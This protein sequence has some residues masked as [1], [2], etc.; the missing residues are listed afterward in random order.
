MWVADRVSHVRPHASRCCKIRVLCWRIL[1]H[2]NGWSG[3]AINCRS[4]LEDKIVTNSKAA[5]CFCRKS[6]IFQ[7]Y[8]SNIWTYNVW[9]PLYFILARI[10]ISDWQSKSS[11]TKIPWH[12]LAHIIFSSL[13]FSLVLAELNDWQR[14]ALH[15]VN[16]NN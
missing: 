10:F 13:S 4:W 2:E 7:F 15:H 8:S 5:T 3:Y 9:Q 12:R 16:V 14:S 6:P 11:M 1:S